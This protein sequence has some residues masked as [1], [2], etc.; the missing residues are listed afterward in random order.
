[1]SSITGNLPRAA[2]L[3]LAVVLTLAGSTTA[4]AGCLREYGECGDCARQAMIDAIL[5]TDIGDAI[6][7]YVDGVDCDIDLFHCIL[8]DSH[9][10]YSCGQ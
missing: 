5:D 2:A 8:Y 10:S 1:M 6:D 4:Y 3:M 9:H 7:A